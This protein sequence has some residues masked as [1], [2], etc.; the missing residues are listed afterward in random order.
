MNQAVRLERLPAGKSHR[1]GKGHHRGAHK[2]QGSGEFPMFR[3]IPRLA[4]FHRASELSLYLLLLTGLV[5]WTPLSIDWSLQRLAMPLH[6]LMGITLGG[7]VVVRFWW[8]HRQL[9]RKS[10][11]RWLRTTGRVIELNLLAVLVTGV[12]LFLHGNPGDMLGRVAHTVHLYS[13]LLLT[14]MVVVHAWRW[15]VLRFRHRGRR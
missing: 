9:L 11:K 15:S 7:A 12:I 14:S 10:R 5:M 3:R 6:V 1:H 13:S 8:A 2:A 4:Y